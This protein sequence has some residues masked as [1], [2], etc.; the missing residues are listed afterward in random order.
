LLAKPN[1]DGHWTG[2]AVVAMALRDAGMEVIYGGMLSAEQ[3]VTAAIQEDVDLIG[4]S[5]GGRYQQVRQVMDL[6]KQKKIENKVVIAGGTIPREDVPLLKE[7]GIAAVFPP[8]SSMEEIV[9]YIEDSM[10]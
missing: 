5:L 3:I 4:L 1:L 8:G 10:G 7:M 2:V 6:L 9:R